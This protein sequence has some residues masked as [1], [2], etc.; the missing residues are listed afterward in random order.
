MSLS[1]EG[2]FESA[3]SDESGHYTVTSLPSGDF[4]LS[5]S[6]TG[7]ASLTATVEGFGEQEHR[8][9]VDF[10]LN[11]GQSISGVVTDRGGNP[12]FQTRLDL[13]DRFGI[14]LDISAGVDLDTGEAFWE[15]KSIDPE[16]GE[17]PFDPFLGFLPPNKNGSEG[18]GFLTYWIKPKTD[19]A[20][21]DRI[22]AIANIVFD[23]NEA[24]LTP[25]IFNTID[26][27]APS[28]QVA[29][30]PAQSVL[31]FV[32]EWS[33][34]DDAGGSG[35]A[36][37][38]V[39]VSD[40]GGPFE[41]WLTNTTLTQAT[42][43]P[44]LDGHTYAFYSIATD[45][46]GHVE[47]PPE[48]PD[49]QTLAVEPETVE[50]AGI[51]VTNWPTG[52]IQVQFDE[53]MDV[54]RM[55]DD[56]SIVPAVTLV[57]FADGPQPLVQ[58]Y[59]AY[60]DGTQTLSITLPTRLPEGCYELRLDGTALTSVAG[61]ILRGAQSG[62]IF[63]VTTFGSAQEVPAA[64]A[65]I[66][67]DAY[68]APA[69]A[70]WNDDGRVDLIVGEQTNGVGKLRVYL[71]AGTNAAPEYGTSVYAQT[72]DGE[73]TVPATAC[74]G[75]FPRVFD[76]TGD[77]ER[78]LMLGLADGRIQV[79]T[80]VG[81]AQAPL[82]AL[83]RYVQVGPADAKVDLDVGDRAT[84][85]IVD[86]NNDGRYDL[87]AGGM[88]GKVR[89][90]L[91]TA[92]T[93][94][95]DFQQE[96]LLY[97]GTAE[98]VVP[99]GRSSVAVAD[100]NGDGRK[101]LVVGNTDGQVLL[102]VNR[103]SDAEPAFDTAQPILTVDG[104]IDLPCT[105][106]SRP[107][108][109]DLN[110]DG[111]TDLLLGAADGLVRWYEGQ[112]Y[113][114]TTGTVAGRAGGTYTFTFYMDPNV[115]PPTSTINQDPEQTHAT[116][117]GFVAQFSRPLDTGV[118]NLY[119][120]QAGTLGPADFSL[121]GALVGPVSGSLI[122]D[123]Q[124]GTVTF[125]KT[126]GPLLPDTYTV[127]FRSGADGFRDTEGHAL[128]GNAD[129]TEGD[130]YVATVVV[131]ASDARV[132]SVPDFARGPEQPVNVPA[133]G[134]G[135]PISLDDAEGILGI[136]FVVD[137]DPTLLTV[138]DVTQATTLPETWTLEYNLD[139]PGHAAVLLYGTTPLAA[140]PVT[141]VQLLASVPADAL[142]R[143]AGLLN[144]SDVEIND[145]AIAVGVDAGVQVVA[146]LGDATGN[147]RYGALDAAYLAR[148][149][150]GRDSGFAAYPLKDPVIVGDTSGNGRLGA[151]DAS[152]LARKVVGRVQ[153]E[154]PDLPANL[155]AAVADGPDPI[156][157][158]SIITGARPGDTI[159]QPITSDDAAGLLG[160]ELWIDYDTTVLDLA[161]AD[162]RLPAALT[163]W[164]YDRVVN[165][166]A[167]TIHVLAYTSG[168]PLP[169]GQVD[170]LEL[171]YH[172]RNDAPAGTSVLDLE[173]ELNEGGLV[174]TPVDGSITVVVNQ[175]P[176]DVTLVPSSVAENQPA[177]TVVG[178]FIT[179][180][181]DDTV[182]T[183]ELVTGDGDTDNASF[184]I[185]NG[186]LTT[187]AVFDFESQSS[188]TVWVR[189]TDTTNQ[190]VER[191]LTITVLDVDEIPP[192]VT[193]NQAVGQADATNVS[194]I[195][196]T[197][198][199][200]EVVF[201][202]DS[203]DVI[204][205]GTAPGTLSAAVTPVNAT[206]Y[207]VAVSGMTGSGTVTAT[208]AAGAAMD[209]GGNESLTSSSTDNEV[210]YAVARSSISGF[211]YVDVRNNGVKDPTDT[212]LPNV[213]VTLSGPVTRTVFTGPDGD[214]HFDN[215]PAGTYTVTETQPLAFRD[216]QDTIGTPAAGSAENDRFVDV[217]VTTASNLMNYNF[218]ERGLRADLIGLELL[219]ASTPSSDELLQQLDIVGGEG[220]FRLPAPEA[221]IL[222][223]ALPHGSPQSIELYTEGW[224][225]VALGAGPWLLNARVEAGQTYVLHVLAD[226]S[227]G[228]D[229][230]VLAFS[231]DTGVPFTPHENGQF[232]NP[233]NRFDVSGDGRVAPIDALLTINELN[234]RG[235]RLLLGP[236][237]DPPYF[238]VSDDEY[239]TALDVLQLVNRLNLLGDAASGEL[240]PGG[241]GEGEPSIG[242]A[243]A[244]GQG[245]SSLDRQAFS[246]EASSLQVLS[247]DARE[248]VH[249][250]DG[251]DGVFAML[252][253]DE[254]L[255]S[256]KHP[257]PAVEFDQS[258]ELELLESLFSELA[259]VRT[260]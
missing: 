51:A 168:D 115:F 233:N 224:M 135:I 240:V 182:F 2:V 143:A 190:S 69:L 34:Q 79:W 259:A 139:T 100:L 76:W 195:H 253:E 11:V 20:T 64:G 251:L 213:P 56:G 13:I 118:L 155:P 149:A 140:G 176:T 211:V 6:A 147:G 216:G 23:Q 103:G 208:I 256:K 142:Y 244:T 116:A 120:T 33:G 82:F 174:I 22:D 57:S 89:V 47:A 28:S 85:D 35:V 110:D 199:F 203:A 152:Y 133:T 257:M 247:P 4:A 178:T 7:F 228:D 162:V 187:A 227:D 209:A 130:D 10:S 117:S 163:G 54:Q 86:W 25:A 58:E 109:G 188:Y 65:A 127:T 99:S 95:A 220:W 158:M 123:L 236:H 219:Y 248:I 38:T 113:E 167:G 179:T 243:P 45:G 78:D 214:Y 101:D 3:F 52:T 93:G 43:D 234:Q 90:Y 177:G 173:G 73:L 175:G 27:G 98:L 231:A 197:V 258:W 31:G 218:G 67:V 83:P 138:T 24:I 112:A 30:L 160:F 235:A 134:S 164:S 108:L 221:G 21:G 1:A 129:G 17:V 148:V 170:L 198:V 88:D 60:D 26:D 157:R 46:V 181:P 19:A 146:Y 39:Y 166:A 71:N 122:Y 12:S 171:T 151:L 70:D 145:G 165:D 44:A 5:I 237:Q 137:Y 125:V 212:G 119:D 184:A 210:T 193:I 189:A 207:D 92:A 59:F 183:Y 192:T 74:L 77:G 250:K 102:Y 239:V 230:A 97:A 144:L 36:S 204:V 254:V 114:P 229:T 246:G 107:F 18:Q 40:N 206:T 217:V 245:L 252:A 61:H 14:Y 242:G 29:A 241:A 205:G 55:I 15:F 169:A 223:A 66:Q 48:T 50:V 81:T 186:Q 172:V 111:V 132:L 196:F 180:D 87:V 32:V 159:V 201:G 238:D 222:T 128:D 63:Q 80:N 185:V 37:Y 131:P 124:N 75:L 249:E 62:V 215:L 136:S 41:P 150:I 225:P 154:I 84:L 68:S 91:N 9:D 104:A 96:V 191:A 94:P 53:P 153:P 156:V 141:L 42:F 194:P 105:P 232:T 72:P 200:S 255:N 202:C 260:K 8:S 49:A 106:R 226:P 121:V 16:T 126:G 161:D